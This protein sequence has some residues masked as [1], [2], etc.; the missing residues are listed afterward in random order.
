MWNFARVHCV[1]GMHCSEVVRLALGKSP[2]RDLPA[3]LSLCSPAMSPFFMRLRRQS[4]IC[5][6]VVVAC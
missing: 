2:G 5:F 4:R 1:R 3:R 6:M